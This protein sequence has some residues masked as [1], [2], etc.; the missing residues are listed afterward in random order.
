MKGSLKRGA[1]KVLGTLSYQRVFWIWVNRTHDI[2]YPTT[3]Y[4]TY[5]SSTSPPNIRPIRP[6]FHNAAVV[7]LHIPLPLSLFLIGR[8][9]NNSHG[10][11]L[12]SDAIKEARRQGLKGQKAAA[13]GTKDQQ[14][15]TEPL[16]YPKWPQSN[17]VDN[18]MAPLQAPWPLLPPIDQRSNAGRMLHR[19]SSSSLPTSV[20]TFLEA[21]NR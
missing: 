9:L 17:T 20:R 13:V 10:S 15:N 5:I 2:T 21:Q 12:L 16:Y 3:T 18:P 7:V 4:F 14:M 11:L 6:F 1:V 8:F 19:G